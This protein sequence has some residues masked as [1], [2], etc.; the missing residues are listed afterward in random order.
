MLRTILACAATAAAVLAITATGVSGARSAQ[1]PFTPACP[2]ASYSADGNMTPLFC[3]IDNPVA[4]RYLAREGRHTFALGANA[5]PGQVVNSVVADRNSAGTI[6]IL[7][8]VY[9]LAAWREHWSFGTSP[10][11]AIRLKLHYPRGWCH[12]PRFRHVGG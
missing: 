10:A 4:L 7:C 12:D 1:R 2:H 6:P 11:Q 8:S 9:R 5:T 3:V